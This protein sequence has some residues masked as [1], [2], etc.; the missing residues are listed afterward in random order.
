MSNPFAAITT[1]GNGSGGT[2]RIWRGE[3]APNGENVFE[4]SQYDY[5]AMVPRGEYRL[6]ITGLQE[7]Y[8]EEIAPQY[9]KEN[10]PI[11]KMNTGLEVEIVDG[12][13]AESR[14]FFA[15]I[16]AS[17]SDGGSSGNKANMRYVFDA[18]CPDGGSE[19][20]EMLGQEFSGYV[21]PSDNGKR[22]LLVYNTC[23]AIGQ[24]A[25]PIETTGRVSAQKKS[26]PAENPFK[27]TA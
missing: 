15:F 17:L 13:Y 8:E 27:K 16:T 6:R 26:L 9:R 7:P 4:D 18:A 25:P 22:M 2:L 21:K 24:D 10:G 11:T 1:A 20:G 5:Y 23:G 14:M 19:M 12:E 3:F